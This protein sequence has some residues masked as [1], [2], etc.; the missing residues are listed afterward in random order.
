M[1]KL[2]IHKQRSEIGLLYRIQKTTQNRLKTRNEPKIRIPTRKHGGYCNVLLKMT[3]K[4]KATK[5]K[6]DKWGYIKFINF[7]VPKKKINRLKRQ[8]T[9]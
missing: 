2:Y 1:G 3:P 7:C 9:V 8:P 6:I 5:A 4:A